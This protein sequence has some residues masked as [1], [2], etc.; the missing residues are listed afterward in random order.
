MNLCLASAVPV[1]FALAI[2]VHVLQQKQTTLAVALL[3]VLG[4]K[5]AFTS[6]LQDRSP[7]P[8]QGARRELSRQLAGQAGRTRSK[9]GTFPF[10]ILIFSTVID[11]HILC[12][13][14]K[15][16]NIFLE[17][18]YLENLYL[19]NLWWQEWCH[20]AGHKKTIGNISLVLN[21]L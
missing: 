12:F 18:L 1:S 20:Y 19:E 17:N 7:A 8:A 3:S 2:A 9:N 15:E 21:Q 6:T 16:K 11:F 4:P 13:H 10:S 5:G 14:Q